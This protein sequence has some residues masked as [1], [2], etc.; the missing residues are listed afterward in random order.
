MA[1]RILE[2]GQIETLERREIPRLIPPAAQ[3]FGIR[4]RRLQALAPG[5]AIEGYLQLMARLCEAQQQALDGLSPA[6][7]ADLR[8]QAFGQ[9][10]AAAAEAG[11]P[12]LLAGDL[13][14][15]PI[16][17]E[18]L[19]TLCRKLGDATG[20]PEPVAAIVGELVGTEDVELE[21]QADAL[22]DSA[23]AEPRNAASAPFVMAALQVYWTAL[24][25]DERIHAL[26]PMADAPGLCPACGSAPVASQVHARAPHAGHRYLA[27]ALCSC[28]WHFVRVQCSRC[29]AMGKDIAYQTL[30]DAES[31]DNSA[32]REAGVRA[33]TCEACHGY[34]KILYEEKDHGV[35]PV[36]DDL[37]S[38]ALDLLLGELGYARASQNPLLWQLAGD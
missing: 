20:F 35:E 34:R 11:M 13:Q 5:H 25:G 19:R 17:R 33:E 8:E 18:I 3:V 30:T 7:L 27:C 32:A 24:A 9:R 6:V 12:P 4:A 26:H 16:W 1:Q 21:A 29:G 14:R 37:A 36:A 38:L 10:P 2:S 15:D 31:E 22:L 28:Q 23:G